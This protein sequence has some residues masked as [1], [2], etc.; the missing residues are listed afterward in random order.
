MFLGR[1]T[2]DI[3]LNTLL[4]RA[5]LAMPFSPYNMGNENIWVVKYIKTYGYEVDRLSEAI[6]KLKIWFINCKVKTNNVT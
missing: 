4:S 5:M 1:K 3:C 2:K 6:I